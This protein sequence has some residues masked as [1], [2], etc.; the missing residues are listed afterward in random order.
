VDCVIKNAGVVL[1]I[2]HHPMGCVGLKHAGT[3][4]NGRNSSPTVSG[5]GPTS[6]L[7]QMSK[8]VTREEHTSIAKIN[9]I[10]T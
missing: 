1:S 6:K 3:K 10:Y 8:S 9:S 7:N 2:Y 5:L 4:C